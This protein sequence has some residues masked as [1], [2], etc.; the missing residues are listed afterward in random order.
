MLKFRTTY[1]LPRLVQSKHER[2]SGRRWHSLSTFWYFSSNFLFDAIAAAAIAESRCT[3]ERYYY[4][5]SLDTT[6]GTQE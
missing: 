5:L 3:T 1:W 6:R 2:F 4:Y